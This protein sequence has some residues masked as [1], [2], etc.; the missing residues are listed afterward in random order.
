[1]PFF[2]SKRCKVLIWCMFPRGV[3]TR[4]MMVHPEDQRPMSAYKC[5]YC[6]KWHIGHER[7]PQQIVEA[8]AENF[9]ANDEKISA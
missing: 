4:Y 3:C 9:Q 7:L 2:L 6:G 5:D 8:G 1:M